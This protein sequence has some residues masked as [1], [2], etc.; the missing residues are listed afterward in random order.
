MGD[1]ATADLATQGCRKWMLKVP[2]RFES[3]DDGQLDSKL[4]ARQSEFI[5]LQSLQRTRR[6]AGRNTQRV[7]S[8]NER[9][10]IDGGGW[11][12]NS[13]RGPATKSAGSQRR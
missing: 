13:S 7:L 8:L 2:G 10:V 11:W 6:G 5:H 1:E 9:L 12:A 3:R 4:I